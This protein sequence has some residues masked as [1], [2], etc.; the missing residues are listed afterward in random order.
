MREGNAEIR[1]QRKPA[2]VPSRAAWM[3]TN[4][5]SSPGRNPSVMGKLM[6]VSKSEPDMAN[7]GGTAGKLL[8]SHGGREFSIYG[9]FHA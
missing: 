2:E 9:G 5:Q 6:M 7:L 1:A 8:P 4:A 3:K